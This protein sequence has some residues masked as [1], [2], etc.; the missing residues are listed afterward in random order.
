[1]SKGTIVYIGGFELPDKNAAA[2]RVV[3]NAKLLRE[4]GYDVVLVGVDKEISSK[5]D[6]NI[7]YGFKT[8]SIQY[9]QSKKDWLKY[10]T[11]SKLYID[12]AEK[13]QNVHSFIFYNLP[14]FSIAKLLKYS[15]INNIKT[16]AD[17][18]E[19]YDVE[20]G[21][22]IRNIIKKI[23]VKFRMQYLHKKTTGVIAIS[24]YLYDYYRLRNVNTMILPPLIDVEDAKWEVVTNV[25]NPED[26]IDF[27]YAGSPFNTN[28]KSPIKSAKDRL[29][30]VIDVLHKFYLRG[31]KFSFNIIGLTKENF[32]TAYPSLDSKIND[33][34]KL[35]IFRGRIPHMDAI[36]ILKQSNY[37]IFFRDDN[38]VSK[39]GF[40]TKFVEA[41]T[42][43]TAVITNVNSN[44]DDF[45]I[46]GKNGFLLR[47][48]SVESV[49]L[50]LH[51]VFNLKTT[52][53]ET[54]EV[55]TKK[56]NRVF[57]Y[58]NYLNRMTNFIE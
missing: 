1:M 42:A 16:F 56:N 21:L 25:K 53:Q 31:E 19:W 55:Y 3:S 29:D 18:T 37:S 2:Q 46:D 12:I 47:N 33:M 40:P 49:G 4:V 7:F 30:V 45:L 57:D 48:I 36:S 43:S 8:Y 34:D 20:G 54:I 26:R 15:K 32:I 17:C 6:E 39:A 11:E 41:I 44:I 9:P 50:V 52:D 27:V 22:N 38:L 5:V 24:R 51:K 23:D 14:A 58:R 35:I 10:I 13:N 28:N